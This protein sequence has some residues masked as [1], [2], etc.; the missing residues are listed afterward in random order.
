ML[1]ISKLFTIFFF[2]IFSC[3]TNAHVQHYDYL[4][5]I[6][7]D[8]YRNNNHVGKHTF[9]FESSSGSKLSVKSEIKFEIKKLGIVVYKYFA[10]G[11]EIFEN[12]VLIKSENYKDSEH[13]GFSTLFS[14]CGELKKEEIGLMEV[15]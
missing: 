8:I 11:T 12:G 7:F 14:S 4:N 13:D 1:R 5:L 10:E 6:E 2:I 9:S 3:P 15:E